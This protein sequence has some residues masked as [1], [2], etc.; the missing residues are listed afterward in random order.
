MRAREARRAQHLI[1]ESPYLHLGCGL[2]YKEGWLNIDLFHPWQHQDLR[3]N[4]LNGLP[5]RSA[6]AEAVFHE[7]LLEHV[8]L[9]SALRLMRETYRVLKP[10]GIVRVGVPDAGRYIQSYASEEQDIISKLKPGRPT[11]LIALQEVFYW[12]GHKTMYDEESLSLLLE[13]AGFRSVQFKPFGVSELPSAPDTPSRAEETLYVEGK[14][15]L[16]SL[17]GHAR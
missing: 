6:S 2:E 3:W 4:L 15:S 17:T 16:E 7:H 9:E 11:A 5:F 12:H 8:S 1:Q 14:V 13:D 10:G